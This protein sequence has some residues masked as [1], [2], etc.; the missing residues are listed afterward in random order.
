MRGF[1]VRELH[2]DGRLQ[3]QDGRPAAKN[4]RKLKHDNSVTLAGRDAAA[5]DDGDGD[6]DAAESWSQW[7]WRPVATGE[8]DAV[9]L[10]TNFG[11]SSWGRTPCPRAYLFANAWRG[12]RGKEA[13]PVQ[14]LRHHSLV[15]WV[16]SLR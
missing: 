6:G 15:V 10:G 8:K 4:N 16:L 2:H 9:H 7:S 14:A 3:A 13:L 5:V 12:L 1:D 11:P